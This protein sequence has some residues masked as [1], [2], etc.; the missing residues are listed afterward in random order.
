MGQWQQ[1]LTEATCADDFMTK[2]ARQEEGKKRGDK[3][4]AMGRGEK[5]SNLKVRSV[6]NREVTHDRA[7][8]EIPVLTKQ[9]LRK[10]HSRK[11]YRKGKAMRRS[12]T[13]EQ[14]A[15]KRVA[16]TGRWP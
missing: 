10:E 16:V 3:C 13:V 9:I 2:H 5:K 15:R 6:G 8:N 4:G 14:K 12:E 1:R 7:Q 11:H